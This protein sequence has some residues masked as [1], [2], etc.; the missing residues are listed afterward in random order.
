[1]TTS[2][3]TEPESRWINPAVQLRSRDSLARIL[4]ATERLMA[5]R[6]FRE[7]TVSEI[8]HAAKTSPTSI[9]ARFEGKQALL[10]GLFERYAIAQRERIADLL[11]L[12]RWRDVP[13]AAA[14]RQ[15]FPE[16]VAGYRAKQGLIR[17]FLDQASDDVRFREAWAEVGEFIV[18]RVTALVLARSFEVQHPDLTRGVRYCMGMAFA[19]V[20][21]QIQMRGIDEP[22]MDQ[23]TEE[24]I[25]MMLRFMGIADVVG[26]AG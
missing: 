24:L 23:L 7:I 14:L 19:T 21:H 9:Y 17:A 5:K 16:I 10:G 6:S 1:M 20:A 26:V 18:G 25:L 4:D 13:L 3:G 15:T 2:Q 22:E 8:A 11:A 12:D